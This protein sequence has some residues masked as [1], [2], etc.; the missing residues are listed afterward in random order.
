[1][2]PQALVAVTV[3]VEPAKPMVPEIKPVEGLIESPAGSPVA[4][5]VRGV[6]LEKNPPVAKEKGP[7]PSAT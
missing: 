3:T 7:P 4:E 1:M 5:K 6:V 2:D